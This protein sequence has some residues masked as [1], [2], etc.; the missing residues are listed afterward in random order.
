MSYFQETAGAH[1]LTSVANLPNCQ[2]VHPGERWTDAKASGVI[3]PG[4]PIVMVASGSSPHAKPAMRLAK[5]GD[6]VST[7]FLATRTIDVPDPNNGPA[8]LGPNEV[9]NQNIPAGEWIMRHRTGVF[10]LTLV[11][12]DTYAPGETIGWDLNGALPA[13]KQGTGAWSK[14]AN[15]DIKSVF[16][17]RDWVEVNPTTHEGYLTVEFVGRSQG[18]A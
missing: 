2:V 7:V 14:D 16:T 13:G 3:V 5:N 17:V 8:S 12:P 18:G 11:T 15:A 1:E 4:Q 6:A 10:V 9:R